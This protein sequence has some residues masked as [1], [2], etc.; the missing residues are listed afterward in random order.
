[1]SDLWITNDPLYWL[2]DDFNPL[3]PAV[4]Y[5]ECIHVKVPQ[6]LVNDWNAYKYVKYEV[7]G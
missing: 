1:M 7:A 4:A 2:L 6:K 3:I 5:I